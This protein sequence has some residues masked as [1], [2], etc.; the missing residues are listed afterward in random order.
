MQANDHENHGVGKADKID[1]S[2]TM[3]VLGRKRIC[4][5]AACGTFHSMRSHGYLAL[6]SSR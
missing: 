3:K 2:Q 6:F 5:S 4:L 1:C